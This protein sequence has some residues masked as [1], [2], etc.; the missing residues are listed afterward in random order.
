MKRLGMNALTLTA[1]LPCAAGAQWREAPAGVVRPARVEHAA[2]R[3]GGPKRYT[4][5]SVYGLRG[6]AVGAGVA[7][8]GTVACFQLERSDWCGLEL[9]FTVPAGM[10]LGGLAGLA[11]WDARFALRQP[12]NDL[13]PL[14][15]HA[16]RY[17]LA[18][19]L[20]GAAAG[21]A[22]AERQRCDDC[23]RTSALVQS[24]PIGAA[25]GAIGGAVVSEV[26]RRRGAARR[27]AR[28]R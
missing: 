3:A 2:P 1:I 22:A 27:S 9:L 18:G 14:E 11:V 21:G 17:M 5:R 20:A 7:V 19:A 8:A 25:V 28:G 10:T 4:E 15:G 26:V 13:P 24:V 16:A 23:S 6:M 12:A